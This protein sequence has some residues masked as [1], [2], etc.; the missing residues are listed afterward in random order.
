MH[1]TSPFGECWKRLPSTGWGSAIVKPATVTSF[2]TESVVRAIHDSGILPPGA[3]QLICGSARN[4]LDFVDERDV[5]TFT[6]S[7]VTG[8]LLKAHPRIHAHSVPFNREAD[9]LNSAILGPDAMPGTPEFDLFINEVRKEMTVK[10]TKVH[11]SPTH[12][13]PDNLINEVQEALSAQ[14]AKTTVG[15]PQVEGV[16]MGALVGN[17]H[18]QDVLRQVDAIEAEAECVF[19]NKV[20]LPRRRQR[21]HGGLPPPML[22][23]HDR[24]RRTSRARG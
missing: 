15:D 6:G 16:R 23:R 7:A 20:H 9:S 2:L 19:G 10:C 1:L 14:L 11:R 8:R 24:T 18:R 17:A 4:I 21:G 22:M 5:V 13:V 3:L 12:F